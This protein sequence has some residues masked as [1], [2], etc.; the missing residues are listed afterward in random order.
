MSLV[1]YSLYFTDFVAEAVF[2]GDPQAQDGSILKAQY[3]EGVRF[4]CWGMALY[5][6]ACSLYSMTIDKLIQT[7]GKKSHFA[8]FKGSSTEFP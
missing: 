6:L 4:G 2:N 3:E 7:F 8:G 1:A 5:S